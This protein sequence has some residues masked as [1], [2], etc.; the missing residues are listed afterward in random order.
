MDFYEKI[1]RHRHE[2]KW[3]DELDYSIPSKCWGFVFFNGQIAETC[4]SAN[5]TGGW[6]KV[7][8]INKVKCI[9]V[10]AHAKNLL[11]DKGKWAYWHIYR[12]GHDH[13]IT[14]KLH[15]TVVII[16]CDPSGEPINLNENI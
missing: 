8:V 12:D 5:S 3:L 15:G 6:I 11:L 4:Q 2:Y 1:Y 7:Y 16:A 14:V 10:K 13:P 9:T